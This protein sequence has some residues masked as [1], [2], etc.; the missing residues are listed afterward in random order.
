MS[1][2]STSKKNYLLIALSVLTLDQWSKWMVERLL[3]EHVPH[4]IIPG[5]L[6]LTHVKNTGVAF[7]L[8]AAHGSLW[9]TVLLTI[10]GLVALTIV[11]IYFWKT[12]NDDRRMLIALSLILGGAVGN[13]LDRV[14]SGQ[15]T[16]FIDA[17]YKSYHWHTFNVADSAITI[18]ICLMAIDILVPGRKQK[19]ASEAKSPAA[20]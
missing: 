2:L 7:G 6:A 8:F 20:G 12:P 14:A 16:D 9:P 10:L 13:L 4:Q 19:A 5:Y 15:V 11:G 3:P 1:S 17:Y 18:G